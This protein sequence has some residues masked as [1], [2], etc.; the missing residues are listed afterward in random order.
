MCVS[1]AEVEVDDCAIEGD[2]C[3]VHCFHDAAAVASNVARVGGFGRG[4]DDVVF[5][6]GEFSSSN[7]DSDQKPTSDILIIWSTTW[8]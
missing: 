8:M 7:D 2:G 3:P 5:L 6:G 4:E 1:Q